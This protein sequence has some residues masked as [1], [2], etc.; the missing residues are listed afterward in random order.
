MKRLILL[1]AVLLASVTAIQAQVLFPSTHSITNKVFGDAEID[2]IKSYFLFTNGN[3]VIWCLESH[4]NY[5]YP[6][7]F[8]L[9]DKAKSTLTFSNTNNLNKKISIYYSGSVVFKVKKVNGSLNLKLISDD[10]EIWKL[11]GDTSNWIALTKENYTLKPSN[12]LVGKGY[13]GEISGEIE[14]ETISIFFKSPTEAIID[15]ATRGYICIGNSVGIKSGDN[16]F[17]ECV[18]GKIVGNELHLQRSGLTPERN[19]YKTVLILQE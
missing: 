10:G 8:G 1:F 16:P 3:N 2:E 18:V 19:N 6:I 15:G 9:Y 17:G 4:D 13:R 12:K 11:L 5:I 7:G 14:G